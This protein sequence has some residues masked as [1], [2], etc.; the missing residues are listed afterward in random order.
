M[1]GST[2]SPLTSLPAPYVLCL[3][4]PSSHMHCSMQTQ[5]GPL[6]APSTP[7]TSAHHNAPL[8]AGLHPAHPTTHLN[9]KA[10]DNPHN[11][12]R[13]SL[14]SYQERC[15]PHPCSLPQL[16]PPPFNSNRA[17]HTYAA[18]VSHHTISRSQCFV[19]RSPAHSTH[20]CLTSIWSLSTGHRLRPWP[21][22]SP[23][24]NPPTWQATGKQVGLAHGGAYGRG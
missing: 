4:S 19:P 21:P 2:K 10:A 12:R 7:P 9:S 23:T 1:C 3:I 11:T 22:P 18:K 15:S 14:H 6:P 17:D 16:P 13:T 20:T 5:L 8:L 24:P